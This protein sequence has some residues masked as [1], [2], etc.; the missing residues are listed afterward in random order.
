MEV[1][2]FLERLIVLEQSRL[3]RNHQTIVRTAPVPL[4]VCNDQ[5]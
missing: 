3:N 4:E 5:A 1:P 2:S